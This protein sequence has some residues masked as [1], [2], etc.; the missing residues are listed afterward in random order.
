MKTRFLILLVTLALAIP[1][2]FRAQAEAESAEALAA[3][4]KAN[5]EIPRLVL[6]GEYEAAGAYFAEDVVQ[7]I[8]GQPPINGRQAW[9]EAQKQAAAIGEWK[10]ELEVLDFEYLGD[11]AVERGRGVQTFTANENSPMPSMQM[12]GD[13]MVMWVRSDEGWQIKWDYVVVQP[14][15]G[16]K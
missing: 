5:A 16:A 6:A 10:L 14:P 9:I 4:E 8:T 11:R 1:K 13:Y 2:E 3:I 12:V 15:V 7:M